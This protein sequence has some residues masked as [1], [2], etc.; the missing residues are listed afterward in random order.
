LPGALVLAPDLLREAAWNGFLPPSLPLIV[1]LAAFAAAP[2]AALSWWLRK[3]PTPGPLGTL[4]LPVGSGLAI[5]AGVALILQAHPLCNPVEF[6]AFH[7][8]CEVTRGVR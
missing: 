8:A 7:L 6:R 3:A 4:V 1:W 2:L 5:A